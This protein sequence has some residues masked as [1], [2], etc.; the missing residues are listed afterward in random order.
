MGVGRGIETNLIGSK[1]FCK[2]GI[3]LCSTE[4]KFPVQLQI[5]NA[6]NG[7]L[8]KFSKQLIIEQMLLLEIYHVHEVQ[9]ELYFVI[10]KFW[11]LKC[12]PTK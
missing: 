2:Q 1:N 4:D 5:P 9:Y 10:Q 12:N 3:S 11:Y 7:E 8:L 6:D